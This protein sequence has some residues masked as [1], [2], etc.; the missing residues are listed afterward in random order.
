MLDTKDN[1]K[2]EEEDDMDVEEN[3]EE[4]KEGVVVTKEQEVHK[5]E[6]LFISL[7]K[8]IP[9]FSVHAPNSF[10]FML[11]NQSGD[12]VEL[13]KE[14]QFELS[15]VAPHSRTLTKI[16][17]QSKGTYLAHFQV[18]NP[19][20]Y[21][22]EATLDGQEIQGLRE[23]GLPNVLVH[24]PEPSTTDCYL[25]STFTGVIPIDKPS[26]FDFIAVD[27]AKKRIPCGGHQ[28]IVNTSSGLSGSI[29]DNKDGSYTVNYKPSKVGTFSLSVT[30]QGANIQGSPFQIKVTPGNY[31]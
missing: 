2:D 27:K 24:I 7:L 15:L 3:E 18:E 17:H 30:L 26:T 11:T 14:Q 20:E 16:E 29:W 12:S 5:D 6:R 31:F 21:R 10:A 9:T 4:K 13:P 28:F 23:K 19:G 22:I 25:S 1:S 8:D